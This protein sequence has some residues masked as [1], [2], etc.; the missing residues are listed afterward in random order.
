M[1]L[2]KVAYKLSSEANYNTLDRAIK[3]QKKY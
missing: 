3:L 2:P 1:K